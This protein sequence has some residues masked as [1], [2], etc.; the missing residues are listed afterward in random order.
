MSLAYLPGTSYRWKV[1]VVLPVLDSATRTIQVRLEFENRGLDLK[2]EMYA[3]VELRSDLGKRL[4]VPESAVIASGA[5]NVV[6]VA[7]GDGYFDPRGVRLGLRLEGVAEVLGGLAEGELAVTSGS[8]LIDSESSLKAAL[9]AA[10][11]RPR[12][13]SAKPAKEP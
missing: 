1:A 11:E 12:P 13:D 3:D 5:R 6:F 4:A 2:P 9:D 10:T 8:F 7:R